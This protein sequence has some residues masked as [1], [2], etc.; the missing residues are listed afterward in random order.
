MKLF[1]YGSG[2]LLHANNFD[3]EEIY[4]WLDDVVNDV[5]VVYQDRLGIT[6]GDVEPTAALDLERK[7]K[8]LTG[9]ICEILMAQK[10]G[11][12]E[13]E[14][15]HIVHQIISDDYR[16]F[17]EVTAPTDASEY[18]GYITMQKEIIAELEKR[19]VSIDAEWC[20]N[21]EL[22]PEDATADCEVRLDISLGKE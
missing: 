1:Y 22:F 13:H 4:E 20:L 15:E 21:S 16:I 12:D 5:F 14:G 19:G 2:E 6:S 9:A 11:V 18:Y 3:R 10:M 7:V 8:D 17:A